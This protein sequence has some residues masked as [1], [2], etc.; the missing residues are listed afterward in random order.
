MK[1][2]T[3]PKTRRSY[4][5]IGVTTFL[6]LVIS[7]LCGVFVSFDACL[8]AVFGGITVITLGAILS[9]GLESAAEIRRERN[10]AGGFGVVSGEKTAT[11]LTKRAKRV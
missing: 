8:S 6:S 4:R 10:E 11:L 7:V 1:K 5:L 9:A 3:Q 2:K